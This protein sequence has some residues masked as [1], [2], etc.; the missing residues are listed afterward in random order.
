MAP[1]GHSSGSL[2]NAAKGVTQA[3]IQRIEVDV[4]LNEERTAAQQAA[5]VERKARLAEQNALPVW[6]TNSTVSGE[7]TALG[8]KEDAARR[9]RGQLVGARADE[10]EEKKATEAAE[11]TDEVAQYY[12]QLARDRQQAKEDDDDDDD[13]DEGEFEDVPAPP[14]ISQKTRTGGTADYIVK[15]LPNDRPVMS[16]G[17]GSSSGSGVPSLSRSAS[18]NLTNSATVASTPFSSQ[19]LDIASDDGRSPEKRRRIDLDENGYE[20]GGVS[21]AIA[22]DDRRSPGKRRKIDPDNNGLR[23]GGVSAAILSSTPP[24]PPPTTTKTT[25]M[26]KAVIQATDPKGGNVGQDHDDNDDN[27]DDDDDHDD[28]EDGVEFEDV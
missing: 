12:A 23:E 6:H 5:D 16:G 19:P 7:M 14:T 20:E 21:A 26:A 24:P 27:D 8:S 28:D 18:S 11:M 1:I 25:A 17:G 2:S 10:E 9:E 22:S 15:P 13:D 3:S 4:T